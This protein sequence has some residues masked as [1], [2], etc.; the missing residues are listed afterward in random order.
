MG[1]INSIPDVSNDSW[2]IIP[3]DRTCINV[4]IPSHTPDPRILSL[5]PGGQPEYVQR[6]AQFES[7]VNPGTCAPS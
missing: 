6:T 5:L 2:I 3:L 4:T 7:T 1:M